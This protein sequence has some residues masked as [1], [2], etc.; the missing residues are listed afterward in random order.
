MQGPEAAEQSRCTAEGQRWDLNG[1]ADG[2]QTRA[3]C[4]SVPL[5]SQPAQRQMSST[6]RRGQGDGHYIRAHLSRRRV[7]LHLLSARD[8]RFSCPSSD[9]LPTPT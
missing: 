8:E 1:V 4:P 5:C 3:L 7:S 2:G 6:G 9:F